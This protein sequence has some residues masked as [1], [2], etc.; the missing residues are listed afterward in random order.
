[1][2]RFNSLDKEIMQSIVNY[3]DIYISYRHR[4]ND[5]KQGWLYKI[6]D[7]IDSA[8]MARMFS[9][10]SFPVNVRRKNSETERVYLGGSQD[11]LRLLRLIR[12]ILSGLLSG[13]ELERFVDDD[14]SKWNESWITTGFEFDIKRLGYIEG[15]IE[16]SP[17]VS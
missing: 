9:V 4:Y 2:E 13:A 3:I 10:R 8:T 14:Y 5:L 12:Y 11:N 6:S 16:T 1:M 15:I 7:Y 17:L